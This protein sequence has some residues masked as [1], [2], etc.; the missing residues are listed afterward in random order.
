MA[1]IGA[2]A[3]GVVATKALIDA[4]HTPIVCVRT[5]IP[6]LILEA[7]GE[8]RELAAPIVTTPAAGGQKQW[9]LL[10]TKAQDTP[11]AAPWLRALCGPGTTVVALQNGIDHAERLAPFVGEA[12]VLP[13]LVYLAAE[14]VAVA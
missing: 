13:A 10:T 6:A 14:R 8:Q 7:E 3:I 5:P 9:V 1:V 11:G 12:G 2:G 4:G